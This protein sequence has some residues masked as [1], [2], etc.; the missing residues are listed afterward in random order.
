MVQTECKVN[1]EKYQLGKSPDL[2]YSGIILVQRGSSIEH[3]LRPEAIRLEAQQI[4]EQSVVYV[5]NPDRESSR[6]FEP[7]YFEFL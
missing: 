2:G 1:G 7:L 5:R 3:V 4:G 6:R